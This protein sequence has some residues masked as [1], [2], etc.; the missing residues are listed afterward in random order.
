M[1]EL[2]GV[3]KRYRTTRGIKTVLNDISIDFPPGTNMGILGRNGA[4]KSTLMR[5]I[6]GAELPTA[7]EV[8][9][10]ASVSW[11]I[12]FSGGFH[13][14][15]TGRENLRFICRIYNADIPTVTAF[16]EDFSEL[17]DYMEMPVNTYSSGMKAKLAFGLSMAIDFDYYLIDEVTAVGDSKFQKKSKE[18]FDRRKDHSTLLVVSHSVSTIKTH[19]DAAAVLEEGTLTAFDNVND[20]IGYYERH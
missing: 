10:K 4:G 15:L 6:S 2:R 8:F 7:G 18:E 3:T 5:M 17:G 20:A 16:V 13:G 1:I 9:R 11:L 19:C 12:G 14:S